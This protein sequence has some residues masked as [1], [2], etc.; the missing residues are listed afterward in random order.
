[1]FQGY[2]VALSIK[3]WQFFI[4]NEWNK[5]TFDYINIPSFQ[6]SAYSVNS[7]IMKLLMGDLIQKP[8]AWFQR[9][10]KDE[11]KNS[12]T[13]TLNL[14]LFFRIEAIK[15]ALDENNYWRECRFFKFTNRNAEK[16]NPFDF[17]HFIKY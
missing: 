7:V 9:K 3:I 4:S 16:K 11:T 1:M 2:L 8:M 14:M 15:R 17:S 6:S 13:Y 10:I 12:L 5:W